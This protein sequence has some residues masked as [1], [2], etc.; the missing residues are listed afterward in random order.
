MDIE[1]L[2]KDNNWS[3]ALYIDEKIKLCDYSNINNHSN[4]NIKKWIKLLKNNKKI[5]DYRVRDYG[6]NYL[7]FNQI[8][9]NNSFNCNLESFS[10]YKELVKTFTKDNN[11]NKEYIENCKKLDIPFIEFYI[12]FLKRSIKLIVDNLEDIIRYID[13]NTIISIVSK[14]LLNCMQSISSKSLIYELNKCRLYNNLNGNTKYERYN[15]FINSKL[16]GTREIL[17]LLLE[18]PL[19]T[20][21]IIESNINITNNLIST[22]KRF[23]NDKHEIENYFN[24]ELDKIIDITNM[25]DPHNNRQCVLK[26]TFNNGNIIVY[27]P[28][29]L[30]IDK[31]FQNLLKWFNEIKGIKKFKIVKIINKINYGWQ[32]YIEFEQCK[33]EF[34][35]KEFFERQG[36]YLAIMYILNG[37]DMHFENII[38]NGKYPILIDLETL[39]N[40]NIELNNTLNQSVLNTS[41]LPLLNSKPLYNSDI[42]GISGDIKRN[43]KTYIINNKY[44]DIMTIK[45]GETEIYTKDHLPNLN[46]KI[47][48]PE[49]NIDDIKI[50]FSNC[51]KNIYENKEIFIKTINKLFKGK[52]ARIILRPTIIYKTLLEVSTNPKYIKSGIDRNYIIDHIWCSLNDNLKK[53]KFIKFENYDL[54]NGDIPIF[55]YKIGEF[56]LI[57]NSTNSSIVNFFNKDILEY[58]DYKI[59]HMNKNDLD[60]QC[61]IIGMSLRK[62]KNKKYS[63]L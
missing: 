58:L 48:T 38:A 41:M 45:Q 57:H 2:I 59:N 18:Y 11:I 23:I 61:N 28:R 22:I 52:T 43:V 46:N 30:S 27:K 5:F 25:G 40:N 31:E 16:G 15:Y 21:L 35:I 6:I 26:I 49:N 29:D 20:R 62:D 34:D 47:I 8:T 55:S 17:S 50:G 51:Y 14:M 12:P 36:Q 33:K 7:E 10:W 1:T 4:N 63:I 44:T 9:E 60:L 56:N 13:I 54:L 19:M 24:V 32:E 39:F 37:T 53:I 3:K 42:S